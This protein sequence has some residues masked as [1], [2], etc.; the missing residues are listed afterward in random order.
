LPARSKKR[1]AEM[2][3]RRR[4]VAAFLAEHPHCQARLAGCTRTAVDVHERLSRARGGSILDRSI[5][6]ALCRACHTYITE[7][8]AWAEAEGWAL[9]SWWKGESA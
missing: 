3:E 6:V 2:V 7:H 4:L 8:P 9:P 1:E 5:F